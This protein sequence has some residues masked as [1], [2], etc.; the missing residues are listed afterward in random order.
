MLGGQLTWSGESEE[1]VMAGQAA[2][3]AGT[4]GGHGGGL[5]GVGQG[6]LPKEAVLG[7]AQARR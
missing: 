4:K 1:Q 2:V 5:A 3:P 6:H 7:L